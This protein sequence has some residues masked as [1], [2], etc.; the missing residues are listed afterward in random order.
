[1]GIPPDQQRLFHSNRE[2][3]N[4][5]TLS[6]YNIEYGESIITLILETEYQKL[7]NALMIILQLVPTMHTMTIFVKTRSG[8]L[9]FKV[10]PSTTIYDLKVMVWD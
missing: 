5:R 9:A 4:G 2:F 6:D 7:K 3:E 8:S 1:M 10:N